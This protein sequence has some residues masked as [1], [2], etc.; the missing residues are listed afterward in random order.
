[1]ALWS[2]LKNGLDKVAESLNDNSFNTVGSNGEAPPSQ[3]G[4]TTLWF[5]LAVDQELTRRKVNH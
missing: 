2:N 5:A 1:L 3:S 4:Q